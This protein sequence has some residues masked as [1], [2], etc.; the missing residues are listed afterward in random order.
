MKLCFRAYILMVH[1]EVV[2]CC[3]HLKFVRGERHVTCRKATLLFDVWVKCCVIFKRSALRGPTSAEQTDF[4]EKEAN[5]GLDVGGTII[6]RRM[7]GSRAYFRIWS[8]WQRS[9]DLMSD[10]LLTAIIEGTDYHRLS[11]WCWTQ[12]YI[13]IMGLRP[14]AN[15]H[16]AVWEVNGKRKHANDGD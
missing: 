4:S 7:R 9:T 5:A 12:S 2:A 10:T 11:K 8:A 16:Q 13:I 3:F 1:F 14:T 15:I 6:L